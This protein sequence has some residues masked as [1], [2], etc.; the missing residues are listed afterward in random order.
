MKPPHGKP[1]SA[2]ADASME[3]VDDDKDPV[4]ALEEELDREEIDIFGL[5]DIN[6]MDGDQ[7]PLF[8]NFAFE[9]WALLSLRF[10]LH[11]LVHSFR[12]DANDPE[13]IGIHPE[14]LPFYYNK[15]YKKALNPKNYG[16][17]TIEELIELV[18]DTVLPGGKANVVESMLSD[19]LESNCIFVK[20]S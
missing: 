4:L 2:A 18:K 9:D 12:H 16:V 3:A 20:L 10:E 8:S 19:D 7:T 5:E 14:H 13:R 11:L 15:Y 1:P 6:N 17:A